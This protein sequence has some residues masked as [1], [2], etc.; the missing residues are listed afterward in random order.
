M[1]TTRL[2]E[3]TELRARNKL[4]KTML[5]I[6]ALLHIKSDR[7]GMVLRRFECLDQSSMTHHQSSKQHN[8]LRDEVEL[9]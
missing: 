5:H 6:S 8:L 9:S 7:I 4:D 1:Q 3:V 2:I